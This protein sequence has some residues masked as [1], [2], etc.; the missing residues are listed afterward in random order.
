MVS[1]TSRPSQN[2]STARPSV[3]R[4]SSTLPPNATRASGTVAILLAASARANERHAHIGKARRDWRVWLVQRHPHGRDLAKTVED[5][6]GDR[7]GGRFDQAIAPD[8]EGA[9]RH[10]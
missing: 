2:A 5:G 4:T 9:A 10:L 6:V 1:R 7:A 3:S 8:A